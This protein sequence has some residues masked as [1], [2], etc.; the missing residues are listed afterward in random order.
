MEYAGLYMML[1]WMVLVVVTTGVLLAWARDHGDAED[2][3][4]GRNAV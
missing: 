2:R 1:V 4:D 3:D